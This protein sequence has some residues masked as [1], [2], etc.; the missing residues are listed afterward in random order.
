MLDQMLNQ[1]EDGNGSAVEEVVDR[2]RIE[3][4]VFGLDGME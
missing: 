2:E 1:A 4:R 3:E